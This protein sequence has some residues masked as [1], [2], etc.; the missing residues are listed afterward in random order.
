MARSRSDVSALATDYGVAWVIAFPSAVM[1][2]N[3]TSSSMRVRI[4]GCAQWSWAIT[5]EVAGSR[6]MMSELTAAWRMS[7]TGSLLMRSMSA[8]CTSRSW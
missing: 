4:G 5:A 1:S 7:M 3:T 8:V 6:C 2:K